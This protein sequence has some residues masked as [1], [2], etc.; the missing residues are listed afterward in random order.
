MDK[1][2]NPGYAIY[3]VCVM[4]CMLFLTQEL[5]GL[6]DYV[7]SCVCVYAVHGFNSLAEGNSHQGQVQ[8][9]GAGGCKNRRP[10]KAEEEVQADCI[11]IVC[12]CVPVCV[13]EARRCKLD[14]GLKAPPG[15]EGST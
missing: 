8:Q 2:V 9:L 1:A 3:R 5:R 15:F 4:R 11:C 10:S 12:L 7:I 14:P 13:I 6:P